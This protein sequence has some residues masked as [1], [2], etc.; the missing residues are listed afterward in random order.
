[1]PFSKIVNADGT[2]KSGK[3]IEAAF[4]DAGIDPSKPVIAYCGSGVTAAVLAFGLSV[5]GHEDHA[6]YDGSWAEWG[7]LDE[8]P[9]TTDRKA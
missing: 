5:A 1:V 9:I 4:S 7:A 8:L 6:V 3:N 2:V